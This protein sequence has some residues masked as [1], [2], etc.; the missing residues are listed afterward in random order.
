MLIQLQTAFV[1]DAYGRLVAIRETGSPPAPRVFTVT[2]A[3]E[4]LIRTR[5]DIA[6]TTSREWVGCI[7]DEELQLK[8]T[9]HRPIEQEY[10]GP[11][12]VVPEMATP[13][14]G[15]DAIGESHVLHPELVARGW[16]KAETAPYVGIVRDGMVVA[17]CYSSRE[18]ERA[19]EAGVETVTD[20][21]GQGLGE[22]AVRA[23]ASAVQ[24]N[25]R[26]ALYSTTW[27][28]LASRRIAEKLG[29]EQFGEIWHLS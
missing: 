13:T 11:A 10:R 9:S 4:R 19:C 21:R 18:G 2:G 24:R 23:W 7:S 22:L 12:F 14:E 20:Y 1:L 3:G 26:L 5:S 29:A 15:A 6:E 27:E 28:N 17:V 25:G 8:V 16:K